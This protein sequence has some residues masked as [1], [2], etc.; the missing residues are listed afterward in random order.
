MLIEYSSDAWAALLGVT[1]PAASF[2][3]PAL[4]LCLLLYTP[5]V[6][7]AKTRNVKVGDGV[8]AGGA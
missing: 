1:G 2:L 8:G 5:Y 7:V 4:F 3:S 6:C